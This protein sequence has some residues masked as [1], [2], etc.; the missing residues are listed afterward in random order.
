MTNSI[1]PVVAASLLAKGEGQQ[2]SAMPCRAPDI[3][4]AGVRGVVGADP[5][6]GT[7]SRVTPVDRMTAGRWMRHEGTTGRQIDGSALRQPTGSTRRRGFRSLGGVCAPA[8]MPALANLR[9]LLMARHPGGQ[10]SSTPARSGRR[11]CSVLWQ[12]IGLRGLEARGVSR[13][14]ADGCR[15][16]DAYSLSLRF[17]LPGSG[18]FYQRAR[19]ASSGRR[20]R[21]VPRRTTVRDRRYSAGSH[22]VRPHAAAAGR[23]AC[24]APTRQFDASANC[25]EP[26]R[27]GG[28]GRLEG[29]R[30]AGW[31]H[32]GCDHAG[33]SLRGPGMA[34][35]ALNQ[36]TRRAPRCGPEPAACGPPWPRS[37]GSARGSP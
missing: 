36:E 12:W 18:G 22:R 2:T 14:N 6:A 34:P 17:G 32:R 29:G 20:P 25:R 19:Y 26:P 3:S 15:W 13:G 16:S 23:A 30:P 24:R 1:R 8:S 5:P 4:P 28:H 10:P 27:S 33:P 21:R 9:R 7:P 35:Q 31:S 11:P 37:A